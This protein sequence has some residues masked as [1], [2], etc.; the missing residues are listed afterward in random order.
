MHA[1][2]IGRRNARVGPV[3]AGLV[4]ILIVGTPG[5][6]RADERPMPDKA[7]WPS[8]SFKTDSVTSI[9]EKIPR[10]FRPESQLSN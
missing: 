7:N 5:V 1:P 2:I 8:E 3:L 4:F 9:S 6:V 10:N